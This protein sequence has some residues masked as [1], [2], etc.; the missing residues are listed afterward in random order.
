MEMNIFHDIQVHEL[1]IDCG[2]I[3]Q[4]RHSFLRR[5]RGETIAKIFQG[6][7]NAFTVHF[8]YATLNRKLICFLDNPRSTNVLERLLDCPH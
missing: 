1:L 5:Y 2:T 3:K 7:L 8:L 4:S 6:N